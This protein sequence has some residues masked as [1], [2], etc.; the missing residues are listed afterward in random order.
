M[1]MEARMLT[2]V[3]TVL[4][5]VTPILRAY[6]E[7]RRGKLILDIQ[8][9]PG[10]QVLIQQGNWSKRLLV[11]LD[12]KNGSVRVTIQSWV[13]TLRRRQVSGRHLTEGLQL[14]IRA[15]WLLEIVRRG[16]ELLDTMEPPVDDEST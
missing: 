12:S 6:A 8:G 5:F 2:T 9:E 1:V 10:R 16:M 11:W 7:Q 13:D 14:P 3:D 15:D 4:E